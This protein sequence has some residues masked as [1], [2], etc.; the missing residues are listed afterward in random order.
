MSSQQFRKLGR[1]LLAAS[2]VSLSAAGLVAQTTPAAPAP[3]AGPNPSRVD[4]FLG[5]SYLGPH[6]VVKPAGVSYSS[7]DVGAI[8]SGAYYFNK[9]VGAEVTLAAHPD[10]RNDGAYLA[11]GG[12]IF[13]APL[14]YFTL[15]AHGLAGGARVGGPNQEGALPYHEP[16]QWGPTLTAGGGLDYNLPKVAGFNLAFRLFQADYNYFH[17]DY[18]PAV[19]IPTGGVLG[20]R[21]N[22]N[23]AQLSSGIVLKFG[24]IVPPPPVTYSCVVS[25]TSGY[26]GDPITVTGTAANL[27]PK[28][29]PTYSWTSD[30]GKITGTSNVANIDTTGVN[31]GTYNVK[32]HVSEGTKAG[33]FADCTVPFTINPPQ[34]PTITCSAS[35]S[36]VNAG[37]SS[38]ITSVANSPQNR[39]LTY[40]YSAT[41]GSIT[42]SSTTAT[43]STVGAAPGSITVTCNVADDKGQTASATTSVTVNAPAV[44]APVSTSQLCTITFNN[45]K[46]RPARIDNEAKACLDDIATNLKR[47]SDSK[48]AITGN[49]NGKL[50]AQRAVNEKAYLTNGEAGAGIDPSRITVYTGTDGSNSVT[51][52]LIP[53]GATA[54]SYGTPVDETAV[55]AQSRTAAAP[56]K[57]HHKK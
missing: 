36:S 1:C 20:G 49:G 3:P 28:K 45:D 15:F 25:P 38:T 14:Q 47:T 30:G 12:V 35:P 4:I 23:S 6:G 33:Q 22:I 41:A 44:V 57:R 24:S 52:T 9:Y 10:G 13:R 26:T 39:P 51:N 42:G 55:K 18:G 54:G 27:N 29:T 8:G 16:Y 2:A 19:A 46:K 53:A 17:E 5:Y 56:R 43:L 21:A 50:A 11:S 31:P 34:P 7:V 40:S 32:G 48:L 37:E